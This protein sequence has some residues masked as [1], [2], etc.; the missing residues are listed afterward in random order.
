MYCG[1]KYH[2]TPN[3]LDMYNSAY[4]SKNRVLW[5]EQ[6]IQRTKHLCIPC[7]TRMIETLMTAVDTQSIFAD[8]KKNETLYAK[9]KKAAT[10]NKKIKFSLKRRIVYQMLRHIYKPGHAMFLR[11]MENMYKCK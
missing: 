7:S 5:T 1:N 4:E 2:K 3:Y 6:Q 10:Q 8:V 9:L 11:N